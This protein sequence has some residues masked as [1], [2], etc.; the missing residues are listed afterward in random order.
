MIRRQVGQEYWLISQDDH[1]RLSGQLAGHFG[2]GRFVPPSSASAI[3]GIGLHDCGWPI[4]DQQPTLN[5]Q[6][7]PRD[8]FETPPALGLK[9]WEAA[10]RRAIEADAYAGLLVSLHGLALS[11]FATG[12]SPL[13]GEK[14]SLTDPRIRFEVNRFQHNM[15]ELQEALR[16]QLELRTDQPLKNGLAAES[17]DPAEQRLT[18]DFRLLQAMDQL[19]L[20]I[21]CTAPPF[22]TLGHL[23]IAVSRPTSR[24]LTLAPWPFKPERLEFE[25]PFRRLPARAFAND[26]EFQAAFEAATIERFTVSL[27]NRTI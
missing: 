6:G 1:A 13:G 4:H 22:Q 9:V 20:C 12:P 24:L 17:F 7:Q 15:I 10:A 8:V 11:V 5:E 26:A 23:S 16:R 21:C 3:L 2:T 25:V 27:Q 19:S 18:C 14:W